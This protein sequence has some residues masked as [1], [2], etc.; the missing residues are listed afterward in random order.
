MTRRD[1]AKTAL[2]TLALGANADVDSSEKM[3]ERLAAAGACPKDC[4]WVRVEAELDCAVKIRYRLTDNDV[5]GIPLDTTTL[6]KPRWDCPNANKWQLPDGDAVC[7]TGFGLAVNSIGMLPPNCISI[8]ITAERGRK[9]KIQYKAYLTNTALE[10]QAD[11]LRGEWD[12]P[13][14]HEIGLNAS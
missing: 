14:E 1:L 7:S 8:Q 6:L 3:V 9:I 11:K 4:H 2:G 12:Y 5:A 13:D 10:Y